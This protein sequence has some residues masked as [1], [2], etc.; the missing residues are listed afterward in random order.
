MDATALLIKQVLF[1]AWVR[2]NAS[3]RLA[4]AE[5]FERSQFLSPDELRELQWT[6]FITLLRHAFEHCD[7]YRRKLSAVGIVPGD[8]RTPDDIAR[9]PMTSKQEIQESLDDLIADNYSDRPLLK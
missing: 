3:P 6:Q 8:V 7:F 9:I 1:P 5:Q 2:K 4:Y